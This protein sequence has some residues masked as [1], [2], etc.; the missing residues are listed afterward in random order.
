MR[1]AATFYRT[2]K[3][4]I[5]MNR[6]DHLFQTKPTGILSVYFTAGYPNLG[7][8]A[9]IIRTLGRT[10]HR[11]DRS[12]HPVFRSDGRRRNDPAQ[13]PHRIAK[14]H[15]P[16][17]FVRSAERYPARRVDPADPDG[18]PE[19]DHAIRDRSVLQKV[20]GDRN[21]RRNLPDLPL[22]DYLRDY[23]RWPTATDSVSSC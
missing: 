10:R 16:A 2:T 9:E 5:I 19:P 11:P 23:N 21:R 8:T 12:R 4:V 18:L 3:N 7:D 20:R 15:V 14:R 1:F 22:A 17:N 6:I 13:Q